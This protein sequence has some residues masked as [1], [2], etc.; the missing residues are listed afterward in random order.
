[1]K[2]QFCPYL[3]K[4]EWRGLAVYRCGQGR[5]DPPE[6]ARQFFAWDGLYKPNKTV[7]R[8]Q[9]N[10]PFYLPDHCAVC[11]KPGEIQYGPGRI[12]CKEHDQA[13]KE[14]LDAHPEKREYM[15]PH[16]RVIHRRWGEIFRE[17]IAEQKIS[18]QKEES[19]ADRGRSSA[20]NRRN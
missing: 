1:M 5:Y 3:E 16:H 13:W 14:W 4:G 20:S 9:E 12:V 15:M 6:G 8:A 19:H 7:M 10:C 11:N 17:F 18:Q 2:C